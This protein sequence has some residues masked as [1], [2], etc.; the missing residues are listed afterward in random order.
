MANYNQAPTLQHKGNKESGNNNFY[1]IPQELADIVFKELG[2]ASA[3]L[4]IMLVL[5]G[6]KPGFKISDAW[7]CERTGLLHASYINAR[8]ALVSRGWLTHE[9]SS[10]ITVNFD[11]IYGKN[12]SNTILQNEKECSNTTLLQRSNTTLPHSS[13]T[14]LPQCSN[15]TLPIINNI[16]NNT[17]NITD[18]GFEETAVPAVS[19]KL[20]LAPGKK[21]P[22]EP[23]TMA[24][25]EAIKKYGS[26]AVLNAIPT[27]ESNCFWISGELVKVY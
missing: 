12:R 9:P 14:I 3:Q 1:K 25:K 24:A 2:N 6:T 5:I 8:K 22:Q 19:S 15:T 21:E 26:A 18:V 27:K 11:A 4:R 20:G 10:G 16:D 13:N 17:D 23:I 7:I